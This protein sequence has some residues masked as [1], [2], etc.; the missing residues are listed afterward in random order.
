MARSPKN[1]EPTLTVLTPD[2]IERG[3]ARLTKLIADVEAFDPMSVT[4]RHPPEVAAMDARIVETLEK[5]FGSNSTQLRR[6]KNQATIGPHGVVM[7][8]SIGPRPGVGEY[9]A[10]LQKSH[11]SGLTMLR[12]ILRSLEEERAEHASS[13]V[14]PTKALTAPRKQSKKVFIVHG[15][16]NEAKQEVAR[17]VEKMGYTPVILHE[18][19]SRGQ[20]IIEKIE[21][22]SEV[23][24]A[25]V[26]LTPDDTGAAVGGAPQPRARQNV[27]LELGYFIAHLKRS[28]VFAVKR[29][30]VE[31]PSDFSGVVYHDLDSA[32]AWKQDLAKEMQGAGLEVDWNKVMKPG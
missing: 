17:F 19:V 3:I 29:G 13:S 11:H 15:H 22:N 31:V 21:A 5:I 23:D 28:H 12:E 1:S 8:S 30:Q 20:T 9:K 2:E 25:I 7:V 26:L 4:M 24:F 32:G 16:D 14:P 18:Q 6:Y 27:I 10:E